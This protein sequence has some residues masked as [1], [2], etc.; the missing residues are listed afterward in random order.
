MSRNKTAVLALRNFGV[1]VE[2]AFT[3]GGPYAQSVFVQQLFIG[4]KKVHEQ[5]GSQQFKGAD[6]VSFI[7]LPISAAPERLRANQV[8]KLGLDLRLFQILPDKA[9]HFV[10]Q[11]DPD[12]FIQFCG[13]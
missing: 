9:L 6:Q 13:H 12:S 1:R 3:L 4:F 7:V 5:P 8:A 10:H 11:G 2:H